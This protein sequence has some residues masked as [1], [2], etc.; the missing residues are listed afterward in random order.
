MNAGQFKQTQEASGNR[1]FLSHLDRQRESMLMLGL[2]DVEE[3]L[4]RK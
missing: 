3:L 2:K 4:V 1:D